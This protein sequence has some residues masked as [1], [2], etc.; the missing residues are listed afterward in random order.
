M[1]WYPGYF[2]N[3]TNRNNYDKITMKTLP[4]FKQIM[5][6]LKIFTVFSKTD[7]QHIPNSSSKRK[8]SDYNMNG[9]F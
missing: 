7:W 8:N 1:R 4:P 3:N 2:S 6:S 9:Q 5:I